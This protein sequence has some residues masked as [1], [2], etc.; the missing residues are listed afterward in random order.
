[1][2]HNSNLEDDEVDLREIF[3]ALW[4]HKLLITL[5]TSL[6]IFLAGYHALTTEKTF[7][8]KSKFQIEQV[9]S[10]AGFNLGGE[11]SALASL[12]G[13]AGAP[14]SALVA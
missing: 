12:A 3:A 13:F 2:S 14:T 10:S 4:A 6:S 7:T 1:M 5:F 8:A 9:D 11:L